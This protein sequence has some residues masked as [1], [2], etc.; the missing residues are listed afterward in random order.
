MAVFGAICQASRWLYALHLSAPEDVL[1]RRKALQQA[2]GCSV[3]A[4]VLRELDGGKDHNDHIIHPSLS[5]ELF[6]GNHSAMVL[7]GF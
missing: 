3:C 4:A 6:R 1:S 5:P 2:A 7:A